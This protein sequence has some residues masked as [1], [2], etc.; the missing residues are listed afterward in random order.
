MRMVVYY[1]LQEDGYDNCCCNCRLSPNHPKNRHR[2]YYA[3]V[4]AIIIIIPFYAVNIYVWVYVTD[5]SRNDEDDANEI[6]TYSRDE[7]M[8][9][10]SRVS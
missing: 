2:L 4:V 10:S 6:R 5:G 3:D 8:F 1:E 7:E 9:Y